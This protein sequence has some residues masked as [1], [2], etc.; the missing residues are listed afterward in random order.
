MEEKEEKKEEVKEE[1]SLNGS[2]Y[3]KMTKVEFWVRFAIWCLIAVIAPIGFM[4]YRFDLFVKVH[5]EESDGYQMTGWGIIGIIII[6]FFLMYI[7][8]QAKKGMSYG[9][10]A[11]QCIDG[12]SA[13]IPVVLI[14]ILLESIKG[15]IEAFEQVL[16]ALIIC[17]A[18]AIPINPMRR[19]A[20]ENNIEIHEG[21]IVSSLKKVFGKDK[22]E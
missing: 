8:K 10:M 12:Y 2:E 19:W 14:T 22:K 13:L 6:A 18:I 16:I 17:E 9:S 15:N 21:I 5:V 3:K 7:I 4:V 20:F 1:S 11:C